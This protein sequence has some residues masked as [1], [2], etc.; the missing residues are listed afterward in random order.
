MRI[1]I[2]PVAFLAI[3][4]FS[5]KQPYY[6][7]QVS[8]TIVKMDSTFD[9]QPD[10]KMQALVQSYKTVLDREMDEIIGYSAQYMDYKRPESL[11]TNLTSDVMKG[12]G[13]EHLPNGADVGV[14]NVHGHRATLPKGEITMGNLYEIYSFDNA[15]TF[16][17][18]RGSD[19]KKIFDAYARIGGA[20][21]SSNVKLV[22]EG[23][24]VKSV[25][26]DGRPILDDKVYHI[27]TLDY[28][29]EGNDNMSAF[30]NAL[31]R[32][33]TGVTLRDVMIGYVREQTRRGNEIVS[34][35][36]GRIV[37]NR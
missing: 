7:T 26:I 8:G 15:I 36:D 6:V 1:K 14:M 12:Y 4:L 30:R 19:L 13:D 28:L 2:I 16:L 29:A 10:R 23:G 27:V 18:L 22:T 20:G 35:L 32:V 21:I 25:S 24:K 17:E 9:I 3:L 31:L 34:T 37:I 11:L 33:D 5:C